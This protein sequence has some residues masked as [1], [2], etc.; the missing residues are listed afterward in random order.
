MFAYEKPMTFTE[1]PNTGERLIR[2]D[3]IS[4]DNKSENGQ[5]TNMPMLGTAST[6]Q[7]F[8]G[9][10]EPPSRTP[11]RTRGL[12]VMVPVLGPPP[13]HRDVSLVSWRRRRPRPDA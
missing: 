12:T 11:I 4:N 5:A 9:R 10:I 1:V 3:V 7:S 13:M 2:S 6:S 8:G